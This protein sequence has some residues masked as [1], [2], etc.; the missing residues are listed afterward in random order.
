MQINLETN[1]QEYTPGEKVEC[2]ITIQTKDDLKAK[3]IDITFFGRFRSSIRKSSGKGAYHYEYSNIYLFE[4]KQTLWTPPEGET[5]KISNGATYNA[6]FTVLPELFPSFPKPI[7]DE[8]MFSGKIQYGLIV[9]I[10]RKHAFDEELIKIIYVR[11]DNFT[12]GSSIFRDQG[13]FEPRKHKPRIEVVLDK[14]RFTAGEIVTGK[15]SIIKGNASCK[16]RN[17]QVLLRN[18]VTSRVNNNPT[19]NE[20]IYSDVLQYGN[21]DNYEDLKNVPFSFTIP[22]ECM[23]TVYG[24]IVI[25]HW[26]IHVKVSIALVKD[27]CLTLPIVV[28]GK[29]GVYPERIEEEQNISQKPTEDPASIQFCAFCGQRM[30]KDL[31]VCDWCGWEVDAFDLG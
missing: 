23:P 14:G 15:F 4:L 7:S 26:D 13:V 10:G 18:L 2:T 16:I 19:Q 8:S 24:Q 5:G 31:K 11:N 28:A 25:T 17:T 1:K 9:K 20:I 21:E 27:A 22:E 3:F 12:S 30:Q 29:N 6:E